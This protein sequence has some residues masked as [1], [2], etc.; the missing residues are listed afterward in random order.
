[1]GKRYLANIL[2]KM[3]H[4]V[5]GLKFAGG[6]SSLFAEDKL[7]ELIE[8]AHQHDVYVSARAVDRDLKKCKEVGF[9]VIQILAGFLSTLQDDWLR[10]VDKVHAEGA[11]AKPECGIQLGAGGDTEASELSSIG[12]SDSSKIIDM[13]NRFIDAGVERI[14]IESE[15]IAVNVNWRTGVIRQILRELPQEKVTFEAAD[16]AVFNW[17]IREFGTDTNLLVGHS[18]IVQ[19]SCMMLKYQQVGHIWEQVMN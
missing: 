12:T 7:R 3:G 6:S 5:D 17:Y 10:L 8:P 11:I 15:G 14:M 19:L 4:H 1:M 18:Q 13:G 2:E 16:P 9:D